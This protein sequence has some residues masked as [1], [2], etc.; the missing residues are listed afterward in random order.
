MSDIEKAP[1]TKQNQDDVARYQRQCEEINDH[2]FFMM[3][4]GLKS[5]ELPA[6]KK[7]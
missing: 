6:V 3:T 4:D 2:G 1:F 7:K 5:S